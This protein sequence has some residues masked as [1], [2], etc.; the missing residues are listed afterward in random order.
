M[1]IFLQ[2]QV[3]PLHNIGMAAAAKASSFY[4]AMD[5]PSSSAD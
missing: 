4:G 3:H 5:V 1:I 2:I